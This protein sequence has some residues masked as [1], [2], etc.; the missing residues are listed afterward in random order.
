MK[1]KILS[2]VN[3]ERVNTLLEGFNQATGFV[4]AIL[5]LDGN[6]LS[7]SGWR[8]ICTDFHRVN[9]QSSQNCRISDTELANQM[10]LGEQYHFYKCVNGLIDVAAPIIINEVHIANLFS[11]QLFFEEPDIDFFI[12]QANKYGFDENRYIEALKKVP[13][14]SKEKVESAMN[15]LV[16]IIQMISELT[17]EKMELVELTEVIKKSRSALTKSENKLKLNIIDLLES[18]RIAHLGTWRLDLKTNEVV[19]SEELYKMYG[20]DSKLPPPPYT[21]HMK[22]FTPESR[23]KLSTSIDVTS[24]T[25]SPYELELEMIK[26]NGDK[27]W[28]W[29]R[30]EAIKDSNGDIVT[31]WGAAQDITD[32]K[33]TE[34]ELAFL[35][36][37][38]PLTGL[39]NRRYF[40]QKLQELDTC[41]N[42]PLSIIMCDFNGLKLINDSFGHEFG[43]KLLMKAAESIK[44]VCREEDIVS[45]MGGDEFAVLL[46]NTTRA[47]ALL[48]AER[49]KE[50]AANETIAH[51]ELSISSGYDTKENI[52]QSIMDVLANAENYMYKHKL[53]ERTSKKSKMIELILHNLFEKCKLEQQHSHRVSKLCEAIAIEMKLDTN[54]IE[55]MKAAGR[56]H[57]IGKISMDEH[58]LNK[59]G[60]LNDDERR[61]IEAHPET[62][63]RI[64]SSTNEFSE[65]AEFVRSHH[66]K[67]DG[68]GYPNGL[69]GEEIPLGARIIT[70]ADAFD[71][72]T[73]H[74]TYKEKLSREEAIAELKRCSGTHFDKTIVDIFINSVIVD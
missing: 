63:W 35:A 17:F 53:F 7:K 64:L 13:I 59:N 45:R 22:L 50:L 47:E 49:I 12:E 18:Q 48:I 9:S 52:N 55:K 6:I 4:T 27:G 31:L 71:S 20:F 38:D 58:L 44:E 72:M 21:E 34:R 11:G 32:R 69:K 66:E 60:I 46:P 67:W 61:V 41:D 25:G 74:R 2:Y 30:G 68:T 40:E 65:L 24:R 42:L 39:Y 3:F 29:V 5:D 57:D 62:A 8:Q 43:D 73:T 28:M 36:F 37:H 26:I 14:V 54:F 56:M 51:V 16:E 15:F 1:A 23:N 19:W 33:K 70:V 10:G